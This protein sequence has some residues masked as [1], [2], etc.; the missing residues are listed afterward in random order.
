[1]KNLFIKVMAVVTIASTMSACVDLDVENT[2]N[3]DLAR[4]LANADEFDGIVNGQFALLFQ[5]DTYPSCSTLSG[6]A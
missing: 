5:T 1:M 3:A 6:I 2:N 4:S